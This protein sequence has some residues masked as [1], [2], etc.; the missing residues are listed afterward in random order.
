MVKL[1]ELKPKANSNDKKFNSKMKQIL[2]TLENQHKL[3]FNM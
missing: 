3:I 1:L 2:A